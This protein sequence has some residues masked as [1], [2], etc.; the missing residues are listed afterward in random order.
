MKFVEIN[1]T[2]YNT[3]HIIGIGTVQYAEPVDDEEY[4][5][6]EI[7]S[8]WFYDVMISDNLTEYVVESTFEECN[9]SRNE[10][11]LE[12]TSKKTKTKKE[13]EGESNEKNS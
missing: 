1:N 11:L 9:K 12:L 10:L 2:L 6:I 3:D 7:E 5:D 13:K 8:G 4:E